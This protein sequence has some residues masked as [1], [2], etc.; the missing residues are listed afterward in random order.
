MLKR[1]ILMAG[2]WV[3]VMT[4]AAMAQSASTF[5]GKPDFSKGD[6]ISY[7]VWSSGDEWHVRWTTNGTAHRFNGSV[8]SE[9]GELKS[10]KR[11]DVESESRVVRGGRAPHVVRGPRGRVVG[12]AGGRAPV[13]V[14]KEQDKI[15][16]DGDHRIHFLSSNDGDIDGFDF[17]VD[18]NVASLKFALEIDGKPAPRRVEIGKTNAKVSGVPF[19]VSLK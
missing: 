9:G 10:L 1:M 8:L 13:V 18:K 12:V 14:T 5:D 16:K 7:Y 6:E 17:K 11:I 3:V 19:T 2:F 4:T 15:E